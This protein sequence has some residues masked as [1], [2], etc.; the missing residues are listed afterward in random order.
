MIP[1]IPQ[2]CNR[3]RNPNATRR[4]SRPPDDGSFLSRSSAG[5]AKPGLAL[6][7]WFLG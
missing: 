4:N 1:T 6:G 5:N 2:G 3:A 7:F